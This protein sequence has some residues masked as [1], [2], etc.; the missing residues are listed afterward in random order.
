M[1][2]ISIEGS[3]I[4][5]GIIG[6]VLYFYF[7]K[8]KTIRRNV[9]KL[10][11]PRKAS[12][13]WIQMTRG[14]AFISMAILPLSFI[15]FYDISFWSP[16]FAWKNQDSLFTL[17][18]TII[19]IPLGAINSR[20]KEH[21]IQYP[22]VRMD[23]WNP[24][25]YIINILSWGIYLLGY[26]YLF[27]GI[28]FLGLLPFVSSIQA[29]AINTTLYA[30]AHLYK[31][32]KETLGSIPLGIILCIITLETKTIWT[33]FAIH[34]IMASNNFI[35]SHCHQSYLKKNLS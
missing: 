4:V 30:L 2:L 33:A 20:T 3:P 29:I 35:W 6:Y 34:W 14:I 7:L 15:I 24:L 1:K 17:I 13:Y 8:N 5:I 28:L 23:K 31:G 25:E 11:H 22:Q 19:L 16:N 32:K 10:F 12:F 27:R 26:E 9:E 21:L 18:L